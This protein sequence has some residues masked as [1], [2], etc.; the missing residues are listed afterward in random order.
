MLEHPCNTCTTDPEPTVDDALLNA[1]NLTWT[2]IPATGKE[3]PNDEE[4]WTLEPSG[5][6]LTVDVW[7]AVGGSQLFNPGSNTWTFSGSEA[8][9][10]FP[11]NPW[12]LVE[13][14]PQAELPGGN[15]FVVGAGTSTDEYP[16][17]C[18][19]NTPAQ[20]GLYQYKAGTMGS[21]AAGPEI[22]TI[23]GEQYASTDGPAATLPD[24]TVLFDA[25]ACAYNIPTHF[26]IYNPAGS[27][28]L[29]Q[30]PDAPNAEN[31]TSYQ[32]R[33]L[34]LPNGQVLYNDGSTD[35]EVY[36]GSGAPSPAWAPSIRSLSD[37]N[38][39]P[40]GTYNLSGKQLAGLDQGAVYGDDVQDNTNFP[41]VR[42]TNNATGVVTYARTHDWTSVSVAPGTRSS[43]E[44]TLP[45]S[46][47]R[48][49]STLVVIANGIASSP[50]TVNVS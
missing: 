19:T 34:D 3:D 6:V 38:L 36:T 25:S 43:T 24:G 39:R 32:T 23:G 15:V 44:F 40:G 41:L 9:G 11:V 28:S 4:G 17:P 46:A 12:P 8:P 18:T 35:M 21:W 31:D 50:S 29:T 10:G 30:I 20:T 48:G 5:Q 42:L 45:G 14:G 1:K 7:A 49:R 13:I 16:N 47:P 33:M 22:P 26:W 2:V 37:N 27:G